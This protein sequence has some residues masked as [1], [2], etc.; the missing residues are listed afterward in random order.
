[1]RRRLDKFIA[2][3]KN[4]I[5]TPGPE[6]IVRRSNFTEW[7]VWM[8]FLTTYKP[9]IRVCSPELYRICSA[10]TIEWIRGH[11]GSMTEQKRIVFATMSQ[12]EEV[13]GK[14]TAN[15]LR[16]NSSIPEITTW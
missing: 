6:I 15:I 8:Y 13:W 9:V 2:P 12:L 10:W 3:Q 4:E 1:M 14:W 16:S 7:Q 5:S 11:K